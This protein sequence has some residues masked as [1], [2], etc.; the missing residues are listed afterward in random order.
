MKETKFPTGF[1]VCFLSEGSLASMW[2]VHREMIK[3]QI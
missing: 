2:G 3:K 1:Y